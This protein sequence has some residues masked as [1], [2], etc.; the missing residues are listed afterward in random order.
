M[1]RANLTV[2][3]IA[4]EQPSAAKVFDRVGI[5]YCCDGWKTLNDACSELAISADDLIRALDQAAAEEGRSESHPSNKTVEFL[6]LRVLRAQ[7]EKVK[8]A[9]PPLEQL[10]TTAAEHN[11]GKYP[12]VVVIGELLKSLSSDLTAHLAEEERNLFP[13]LLQLELA[14]L[15]ENPVSGYPKKVHEIVRSMS[16]QHG[17]VGN[18]LR[19]MS[20]E[21][22]GFHLPAHADVSCREFYDA[23]RKFYSDLQQ[24]FHVE[25]NILFPQ[26]SQLEAAIFNERGFGSL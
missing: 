5:A 7:H 23:L 16:E 17:T 6:I 22:S 15:G 19:R 2:S 18:T 11:R 3:R 1:I 25:N 10:A 9:L 26:A 12:E 14:Y 21:S 13:A 20:V 4:M 24:D 8:Q